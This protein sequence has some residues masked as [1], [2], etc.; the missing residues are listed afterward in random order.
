[1]PRTARP[2]HLPLRLT[3]PSGRQL[4]SAL[5]DLLATGRLADGDWLPS[6]RA[7]ASDLGC[8][9]SLVE[10]AY[11]ELIA[12]GFFEGIPG[13]GTRVLS[14]ASMAAAAGVRTRAG[15]AHALEAADGPAQG[16]E[17]ARGGDGRP[18][19]L[20]PGTPDT[21]LID[22]R[23]WSRAWR[24]AARLPVPGTAARRSGHEALI[25]ALR[26]HLRRHRGLAA[27][28]ILP[29]PG[30]N[31]A[32]RTVAACAGMRRCYLESP[33]YPSAHREFQRAGMEVCFIPVDADGLVVESLPD[34]PGLVYLT[35][36]HQYPLG[37]RLSAERRALLVAWAR[38][39]GSVVI[40]DD[41]DGEF[42]YGVAPL[43]AVASVPGAEDVVAYVGTA[44]KALA[45]SLGLA[46]LI[47]PRPLAAPA[48]DYVLDQHLAVPAVTGEA[49]ARFLDSGDMARHL[50]RAGR[51]YHDRRNRLIDALARHCPD[52]EPVGVEAGLHVTV[53]LPDLDDRQVQGALRQQ[54]WEVASL[55]SYPAHP[56]GPPR[57]G[58]VVGYASLTAAE[59]DRF[60]TA[61]AR[62]LG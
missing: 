4:A 53:P 14:G 58:L 33:C 62:V 51:V 55:S 34:E 49:M 38:R 54:G 35:P 21:T 36:A 59:A 19:D 41:Y 44:S 26:T 28:D 24:E 25:A 56:D 8:S 50:A 37:H 10:G 1:M 9:R 46:W 60:A 15:A 7:L 18:V 12:A 11:E 42:R 52:L 31:A 23:A 16:P 45:P 43:P 17:S 40:E 13:S 61:L 32:F 29:L 22:A 5:V 6:T 3:R 39:T 47:P 30:S 20:S 2:V 27:G 57:T 48:R